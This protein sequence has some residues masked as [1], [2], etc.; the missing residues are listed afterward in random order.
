MPFEET[1]RGVAFFA[2]RLTTFTA[3]AFLFGLVPVLVFVLRPSFASVGD[4]GWSEGRR[5]L[6]RRLEDLVQAALVASAVATLVGL[7]LQGT[8]I[9][10]GLGTGVVD[11]ETLSAVASTPFGRW[12]LARFPVLAALAVLLVRH[13]IDSAFAG[14][15]DDRKAPSTVWWGAWGALGAVLFLTN[16]MSGHAFVATPKLVSIPNDVI[17]LASGATW[18]TGIVLLA[19]ALPTAWRGKD[20]DERLNLL[21]PVVVRFSK[22]AAISIGIVAVTGTINSFLDI[23]K[24]SDLIETR[25][26]VS[27][28]L[29]I[30]AFLG[31]LALGGINHFYVRRKLERAD[32]PRSTAHL[33]RRTIAI[34]LALGVAIMGLTAVLTGQARTREVSL[35]RSGVSSAPRL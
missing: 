5:R 3:H 4:A 13:V 2:A 35:G 12:H 30:A 21:T 1:F 23:G 8:L 9:A 27:L 10:E 26:G 34:E 15:G 25:Y 33:F 11:G 24:I 31:V 14:A 32:H 7:V 29:K 22:V 19:I 28:T 16:S 6:A 20:D 17:H 18:L